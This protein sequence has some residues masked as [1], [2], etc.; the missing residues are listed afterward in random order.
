MKYKVCK[1]LDYIQGH[2]RYGHAET[3]VEAENEEEA[4]KLAEKE[5]ENENYDVVV[6]DYEIEDVGDFFGDSYIKEND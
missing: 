3:I 4:L 5:F 6:D 2:L 1:H